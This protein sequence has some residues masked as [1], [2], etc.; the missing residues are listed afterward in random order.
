MKKLII[1]A[2]FFSVSLLNAQEDAKEWLKKMNN[3]YAA[4]KSVRMVFTVDYYASSIQNTPSS[5]SKGEVRYSGLNYYSDAMG[6]IIVVN[7]HYSLLINKV[8]HTI[9]CLPGR[10]ATKKEQQEMNANTIAML[11]SSWLSSS[12]LKLLDQSGPFR[13]IEIIDVGGIY[14]KT[15]LKINAA[16]FALEEVTYYYSRLENGSS[17]KLI[18]TYSSVS[19]NSGLSDIDFTEKNYIRKINGKLSPATAWN[20]YQ[21]IDLTSGTESK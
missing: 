17:P 14:E 12:K 1:I 16:T 20:N 9:T 5:S 6:Q 8:E 2:L 4:A 19:F 3:A 18:I 15:E 7:K 13:R 11:D 10:D 21:V